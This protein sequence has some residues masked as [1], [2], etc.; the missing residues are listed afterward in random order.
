MPLSIYMLAVHDLGAAIRNQRPSRCDKAPC[1]P[2]CA[3]GV[4]RGRYQHR[5]LPGGAGDD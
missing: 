3:E 4:I 1:A 5:L 2:V